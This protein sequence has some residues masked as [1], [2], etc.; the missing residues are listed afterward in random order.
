MTSVSRFVSRHAAGLLAGAQRVAAL[1]ARSG[2]C[3]GL[4]A[5]HP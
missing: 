2:T 3:T 4:P 1:R 5:A